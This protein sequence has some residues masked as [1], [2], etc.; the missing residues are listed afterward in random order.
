M[1]EKGRREK[2]EGIKKE[3]EEKIKPSTSY[4]ERH[5]EKSAL[6]NLSLEYLASTTK[7]KLLLFKPTNPNV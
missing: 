3:E 7:R 6:P 1:G 4:I 2:R 5:R